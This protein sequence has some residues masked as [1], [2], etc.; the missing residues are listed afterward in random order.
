M[1]DERDLD[2]ADGT[3]TADRPSASEPGAGHDRGADSDRGAGSDRDDTSALPIDRTSAIPLAQTSAFP[4]YPGPGT[5][6]HSAYAPPSP[7]GSHP[8]YSSTSDPYAA[9]TSDPY[10]S[11]LPSGYATST[12]ASHPAYGDT[13]SQAGHTAYGQ[14]SGATAPPR[15]RRS[16]GAGLL[17]GAL[18]L[19]LVGGGAAGYLGGL[20]AEDEQ[21]PTA[22]VIEAAP[23]GTTPPTAVTTIAQHALPSVVFISVGSGAGGGVGSGFVVRED[24][25]LV[26]NNHVVEGAGD[27]GTVQVTFSDGREMEAEIVGADAEYD[28]A[29]L[30]VDETG[31]QPLEFGNSDELQVGASV[32][33]V[34]APL[35]LDNTVTSGIVSALNRPVIA[36]GGSGSTSYINAIQ[37]DAAINPGNSG[38][39]LLDLNGHVVGVNSA[40]AQIPGDLGGGQS[41]SIGLGF[42][43]PAR[44]VEH[45][46]NQLIETGSSNHPIIGVMLDMTHTGP[47]AKV[48]EEGLADSPSIVE[49]GPADEAGVEP[50]DLILEVDGEEIEHGSHLIIVLRSHVIGDEVELLLRSPD[51][52]ERTV[53]MTLQG[54]E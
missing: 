14:G 44:Q 11:P 8:A 36:G 30:K 40:I 27:N 52:E 25:Y 47:G 42:A 5:V 53:T 33:A 4:P 21:E 7:Q 1:A 23:V 15:P 43:I 9:T 38:G 48:L 17:V 32:V 41:G 16:P 31:L 10:A 45:T 29:V 37:T 19:G 51:G 13:S 46:A 35:G 12:P 34:G 18:A 54:S 39:P 20:L 50:G 3:D 49:G 26:T 22:S 2:D 24:G 28:I 6:G